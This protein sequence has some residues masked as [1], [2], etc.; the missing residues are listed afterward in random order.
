M[1]KIKNVKSAMVGLFALGVIGV[2]A[3]GSLAYLTDAEQHV[4]VVTAGEVKIDLEEPTWSET[5][6]Q[7][8]VPNKVI[9]KDPLIEN[10]GVNDAVVFMTVKVPLR[11]VTKVSA[12]GTKDPDGQKKQ[13]IFYFQKEA[14]KGKQANAWNTVPTEAD[15]GWRLI[16]MNAETA[17]AGLV[18]GDFATYTFAWNQKLAK[19]NATAKL[20]DEI[21][22]KNVIE[23]ELTKGDAQNITVTAFAIQA[24][25][26]MQGD[27][28]AATYGTGGKYSDAEL[29]TIFGIV[30]KQG[31]HG[32]GDASSAIPEA[33]H[34]NNK[35]LNGGAK[36][37]P[38]TQEPTNP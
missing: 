24:S 10:T 15:N 31:T 35:D 6:A 19:D 27:N 34:H 17:E 14:E 23:T 38:P 7:S 33:D 29:K 30:N 20:F 12:N 2:G 18:E 37:E 16:Q 26:I 21:Q 22:M 3:A 11:T 8:A 13:E 5:A 28:T 9:A 32:D 1:K 25:D 4:N 36:T